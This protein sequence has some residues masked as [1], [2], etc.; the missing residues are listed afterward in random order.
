MGNPN[1]PTMCSYWWRIVS[2]TLKLRPNLHRDRYEIS[3]YGK[4]KYVARNTH[5]PT[6]CHL[7]HAP[8]AKFPPMHLKTV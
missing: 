7:I 5:S 3:S 8:K 1:I 4:I 2:Q 6:R